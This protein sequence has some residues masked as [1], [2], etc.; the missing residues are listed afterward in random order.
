MR[1]NDGE[2][3]GMV[4]WLGDEG[5]GQ[6]RRPFLGDGTDGVIVCRKSHRCLI[7][8]IIELIG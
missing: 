8:K 6:Q 7:I 4:T 5:D 3:M 1:A 2:G